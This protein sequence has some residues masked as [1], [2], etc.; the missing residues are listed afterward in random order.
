MS[1]TVRRATL[2]DVP[3]LVELV[4]TERQDLARRQPV[5]WRPHSEAPARTQLW[6]S[7]LLAQESSFAFLAEEAGEARG[8]LLV[9]PPA[10]PPVY[11]PGRP[12]FLVDDFV[13]LPGPGRAAMLGALFAAAEREAAA[14]GPAQFIVI[15]VTHDED[16]TRLLE[17]AGL[18][19][20]C[21]WWTK[22]VAPGNT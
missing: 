7:H 17:A 10:V 12:A 14:R 2:E 15:A 9:N 1:C 22:P 16:K 3:K 19:P 13:V 6:F 20:V 4:T 18:A 5:F 11:D 21:R 8:F